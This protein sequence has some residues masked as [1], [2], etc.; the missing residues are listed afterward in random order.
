MELQQKLIQENDEASR[1]GQSV[2][3]MLRRI[4]EEHRA[5]AMF[6]VHKLLFE[7]QQQSK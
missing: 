5:Q 3:D 6:D 4:P 1:F 2:A 7:R